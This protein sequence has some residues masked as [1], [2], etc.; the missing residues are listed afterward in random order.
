MRSYMYAYG[1]RNLGAAY[2]LVASLGVGQNPCADCAGCP[3]TCAM[4]FD[5]RN[6]ATA[7]AG[8]QAAPSELFG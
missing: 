1:Y 2:D 7:I 5:V 3:V 4:G 8:L 6:R